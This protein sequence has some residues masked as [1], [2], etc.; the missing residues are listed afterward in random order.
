[1]HG[2]GKKTAEKLNAIKV[3]TIGDLANAAPGLLKQ[4]LGVKEKL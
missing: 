4:T 1:M 3:V 2:I